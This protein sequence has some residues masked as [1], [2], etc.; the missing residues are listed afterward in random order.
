MAVIDPDAIKA[1]LKPY[2]GG[3]QSEGGPMDHTRTAPPRRYS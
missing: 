3:L 1:A 2:F